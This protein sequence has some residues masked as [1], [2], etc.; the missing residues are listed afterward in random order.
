M[1]RP[2]LTPRLAMT[3]ALACTVTLG[4]C[5]QW[6]I[7]HTQTVRVETFELPDAGFHP[8]ATQPFAD[9]EPVTGDVTWR[10]P[11][12]FPGVP[13]QML[14]G[15]ATGEPR[16]VRVRTLR[17]TVQIDCETVAKNPSVM[18]SRALFSQASTWLLESGRAIGVGGGDGRACTALLVDGGGVPLHLLF[19]QAQ[20]HGSTTLPS[21]VVGAPQ[22]RLLTL[23]PSEGGVDFAPRPEV[24][25]PPPLLE[26]GP[27]PGCGTEGET[28]AWS[29][30]VPVGNLTILSLEAAP[31]GCMQLT[32][33]G[34]LGTQDWTLCL[35]PGTFPYE[36]GDSYF[37][38]PLTGGHDLKAIEG[39]ELLADKT[40]LR[41]GR[42][43]DLVYFG[44]GTLA[45]APM[46]GCAGFHDAC[47]DL[48]APLVAKIQRPNQPEAQML[49][50]S[51]LDLGQ[52]AS[53]RLLQASSLPVADT[54]CIAG[55][56]LG[57]RHFESV[58]VQVQP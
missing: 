45:I 18:L 53:L 48:Q 43:D 14:I 10:N 11:N 25:A 7:E 5:F 33:L 52:G 9:V 34:K 38:A 24:L 1:R 41:F 47:G 50:G 19:W 57:A 28:L 20:D 58:Y 37:A 21:T 30:P 13:G 17:P 22:D 27:A 2:S 29:T 44:D 16:T 46:P 3:L 42:G 4:G 35:P 51:Q 54:A 6:P 39:F 32:L 23:Q 49:T 31:D 36:E 40:K 15:N 55:A 12:R 8:D 56:K 26:P